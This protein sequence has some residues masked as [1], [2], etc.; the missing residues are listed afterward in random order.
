MIRINL[1]CVGEKQQEVGR[2]AERRLMVLGGILIVTMFAAVEAWS[3]ARIVPVRAEYAVLQQQVSEL[4]SKATELVEVQKSKA[5]L[6]D[7]LKTIESLQQKK[8][9][10]TNVLADLSDAAP[11]HVWLL[12]FT[13]DNGAATITGFAFDN[14]TIATFMRNLGQS[15]YFAEVDLVETQTDQK[16]AKLKKFVVKARVSYTGEPLPASPDPKHPDPA[17]GGTPANKG[18]R[19]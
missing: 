8:V 9:G 10:P 19:V 3:R 16:D 6:G 18:N 17:K 15:K 11:E 7:K 4:N 14:Q 12:E 2:R 13:E 1:L 5:E